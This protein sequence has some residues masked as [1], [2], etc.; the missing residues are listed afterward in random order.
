MEALLPPR[1]ARAY[2]RLRPFGM[3]VFVALIAL[4]WL[5]PG[6]N[7]LGNTIGVPVEWAIGHYLALADLIGR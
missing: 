5:A 6:L 3:L 7:L 4:T 1:A 2:E